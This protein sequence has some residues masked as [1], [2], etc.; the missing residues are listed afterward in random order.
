MTCFVAVPDNRISAAVFGGTSVDVSF[1]SSSS[2]LA[3]TCVVAVPDDRVP[4]AVWTAGA[5][6]VGAGEG[7]VCHHPRPRHAQAGQGQ[8]I[9]LRHRHVRDRQARSVS[10]VVWLGLCHLVRDEQ[11]LA[12]ALG[13][14]HRHHFGKI[15]WR[16]ESEFKR[17]VWSGDQTL[18]MQMILLGKGWGGG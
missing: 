6:D 1:M 10:A 2:N 7:G 13:T 4:A 15:W 16:P 18:F 5:A 9:P 14:P 11:A 12:F 17:S 8:R 3:V